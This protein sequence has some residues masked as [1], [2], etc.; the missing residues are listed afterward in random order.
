MSAVN[1]EPR[2]GG[3]AI[4]VRRARTGSIT[5]RGGQGRAHGALDLDLFPRIAQES[6]S[7]RC[8]STSMSSAFVT[9]RAALDALL[10]VGGPRSPATGRRPKLGDRH[11]RGARHPRIQAALSPHRQTAPI[12]F[13]RGPCRDRATPRSRRGPSSVKRAADRIAPIAGHLAGD[14]LRLPGGGARHRH[15]EQRPQGLRRE[16]PPATLDAGKERG[17]DETP[18]SGGWTVERCSARGR[19]RGGGASVAQDSSWRLLPDN[20]PTRVRRRRRRAAGAL[21]RSSVARSCRGDRDRQP[22]WHFD[23][24]WQT[25][26]L[27][28]GHGQ[29][30]GERPVQGSRGRRVRPGGIGRPG[31]RTC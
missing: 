8:A 14:R 20:P 24:G 2:P 9:A 31:S 5:G 25:R 11:R 30:R 29:D 21:P 4:R 10:G 22:A 26:R 27:R 28:R 15:L 1:D 12:T 6:S 7:G 18:R 17:M 16:G 23:D 13:P 19:G 3:D